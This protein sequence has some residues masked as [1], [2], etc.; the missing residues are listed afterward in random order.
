MSFPT[1]PSNKPATL[2]TQLRAPSMSRGSSNASSSS[3]N[4][5]FDPVAAG[6]IDPLPGRTQKKLDAI[7]LDT[8]YLGPSYCFPAQELVISACAELV[9]ERVVGGDES[10]LWRADGRDAE[11]KGLKGWLAQN[12]DVVKGEVK[13]DADET[14]M[15]M[16]LELLPEEYDEED[17]AM[18]MREETP[19]AGT[20]PTPS[21]PPPPI[22]AAEDGGAEPDE[23]AW[24]AAHEQSEEQ[25]Q[26]RGQEAPPRQPDTQ[27]QPG[28]ESPTCRDAPA[29]EVEQT[30]PPV[31]KS[32]ADCG[33][34]AAVHSSWE[35][36][37]R[38]PPVESGT[39]DT[40][41]STNI[42]DAGEVRL[43]APAELKPELK[44]RVK[45]E[46]EKPDLKPKTERLLVL[47]GTYSIGKERCVPYD[48]WAHHRASPLTF[49]HE[50]HRESDR[51]RFID[52]GLLRRLQAVALSRSG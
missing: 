23:E 38:K 1:P 39:I 52:Q 32:E 11:R 6:F 16:E 43:S 37:D 27:P 22:V 10:A 34:K 12:D 36:E 24:L 14:S 4:T 45:D 46:D 9:K 47:I 31:V 2:Q 40:P 44:A 50:K 13:D 49:A 51:T 33:W 28:V 18:A 21:R 20:R 15:M 26:H 17:V 29:A 30:P 25:A 7:Y 8:T 41:G 3:T 5:G 48:F 35:I 42:S 19:L